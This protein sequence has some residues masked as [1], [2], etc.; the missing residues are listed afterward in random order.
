MSMRLQRMSMWNARGKYTSEVNLLTRRLK[1]AKKEQKEEATA[2][3]LQLRKL[4][5]ELKN[6]EK[7][8]SE[9]ENKFSE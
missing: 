1:H 8:C 7:A 6:G 3:E 5:Q 2:F 4:R 9:A